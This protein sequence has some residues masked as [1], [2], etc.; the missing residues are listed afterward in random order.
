MFAATGTRVTASH[1][2]AFD[3]VD[4]VHREMI[5]LRADPG[6]RAH[7]EGLGR[8]GTLRIGA[9]HFHVIP[10][11]YIR[12][13]GG[14]RP[15][16]ETPTAALHAA[17][18]GTIPGA[19]FRGYDMEV[20]GLRQPTGADGAELGPPTAFV[21][22]T[23]PPPTWAGPTGP[24][25]RAVEYTHPALRTLAEIW[26]AVDAVGP[27]LTDHH[28]AAGMPRPAPAR[29]GE[30]EHLNTSCSARLL[31]GDTCEGNLRCKVGDL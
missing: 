18:S 8:T 27:P 14:G 11:T 25:G 2:E 10:F 16:L 4:L 9:H 31:P 7:L 17:V 29:P 26:L 5:V 22:P 30:R 23:A 19:R 6:G 3:P 15:N 28:V 20:T 12:S 13:P 1:S 21:L 24:G